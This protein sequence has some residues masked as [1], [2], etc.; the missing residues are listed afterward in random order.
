MHNYSHR[1]IYST[2]LCAFLIFFVSQVTTTGGD[3]NADVTL[4][5]YTGLKVTVTKEVPTESEIVKILKDNA[6]DYSLESAR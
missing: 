4:G 3:K 5:E 6:K 2:A 1:S